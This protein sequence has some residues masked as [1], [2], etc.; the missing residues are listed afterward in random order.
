VWFL[1]E[2]E[3]KLAHRLGPVTQSHAV[4]GSGVHIPTS[5]DPDGFRVRHGLRRPFVLYAGRREPLKGWDWLLNTYADLVTSDGLDLDLVTIGV[6]PVKP[7]AAVADRV[8][9]LGLV[10]PVERDNAFSAA[11]AYLQPSRME[12]FSRTTMEAWLAGTVVLT[13]EESEVVAWHCSRSGGGRTFADEGQLKQ[14]LRW[15]TDARGEAEAMG[16]RGRKYVLTEYTWPVVLDRMEASL[17]AM[18][19]S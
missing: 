17:K 14:C 16:E 15:L 6:G 9:D 18:S 19:S 5:Y 3:H 2:P 10:D 11:Q 7:P 8:I 4:T 12:S 1:S 13:T